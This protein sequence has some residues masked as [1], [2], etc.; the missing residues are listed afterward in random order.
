MENKAKKTSYSDA[1]LAEFK[2]LIE[3]KL[4]KSRNEL[5]YLHDQIKE[6]NEMGEPS[7]PGDYEE[8]SQTSEMEYLAEMA[9]RQSSFIRHMENALGRIRRKTYGVCTVTGKLIEKRRLMLVPHATKSMEAKNN[10]PRQ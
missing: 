1:E 2:A 4:E 6:L 10:R 9:T 8:G 5:Q 3:S 7:R